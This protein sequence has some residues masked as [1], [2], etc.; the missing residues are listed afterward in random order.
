MQHLTF[1][2]TSF[3]PFYARGHV[4]SSSFFGGGWVWEVVLETKRGNGV[5]FER[6]AVKD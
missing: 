2:V 5:M 6:E 4:H 1:I 3:Q